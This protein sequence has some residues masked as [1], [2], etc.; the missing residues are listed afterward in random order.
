MD[1]IKLK[2]RRESQKEKDKHCP[3]TVYS[4]DMEKELEI[5]YDKLGWATV[6]CRDGE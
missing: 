3:F 2:I 6:W 4:K 1:I 5:A